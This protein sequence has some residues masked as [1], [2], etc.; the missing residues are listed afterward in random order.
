M[1]PQLFQNHVSLAGPGTTDS[2]NVCQ[3][4]RILE[5]ALHITT[6]ITISVSAFLGAL[7]R[8]ALLDGSGTT[9]YVIASQNAL[10]SS[11]RAITTGIS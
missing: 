8:P 3:N 7:L 9:S 10:P 11:V 2:A 5:N 4:A 1:F 6:G